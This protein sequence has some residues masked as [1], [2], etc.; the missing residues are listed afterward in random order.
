MFSDPI[1]SALKP[2]RQPDHIAQENGKERDA[3]KFEA[4]GSSVALQRGPDCRSRYIDDQNGQ[5]EF[6]FE[7]PRRREMPGQR[8]A[9]QTSSN[10]RSGIE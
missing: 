10:N 9:C 5:Q 4:G 6:E 2:Q 1:Q 8:Q 3:E 7:L